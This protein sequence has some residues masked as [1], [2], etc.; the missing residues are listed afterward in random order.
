MRLSAVV[1]RFVGA[2]G[3]CLAVAVPAAAPARAAE[4]C[5]PVGPLFHYLSDDLGEPATAT[6]ATF[7]EPG[8]V[9]VAG[10]WFGGTRDTLGVQ[11]GTYA[12]LQADL[13]DA[14]AAAFGEVGFSAPWQLLAGDWDDD[15]VTDTGTFLPE[16]GLFI[17]RTPTE[18]E[19]IHFGGGY[20]SF[21]L[22]GD[23]DGDGHDSIGVY[24]PL[25]GDFYL[26]NQHTRGY[27]MPGAGIVRFGNGAAP[28][29]TVW[30]TPV[31][32]D[33]DGDGIDT[34][35]V[36]R[37]D[38]SGPL[39]WYLTNRSQIPSDPPADGTHPNVYAPTDVG[40]TFGNDVDLAAGGPDPSEGA[41]VTYDVPIVGDWNGDG[42]TTPG[43]ARASYSFRC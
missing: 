25:T 9:P 43:I 2:V 32:G 40:F 28:Y 22:T 20:L 29:G 10:H 18:V 36:V 17:L 16:S 27:A 33:W 14:V 34:V 3:L 1:G 5:T 8:D 30:D 39:E 7:G 35:G 26:S 15:G 24:D 42:I 11:R 6:V 19:E 21:A 12:Y 38:A 31:V 13:H 23:W 41:I 37:R 4:A